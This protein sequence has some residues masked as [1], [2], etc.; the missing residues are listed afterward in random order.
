MQRFDEEA[1]LGEVEAEDGRL[2]L[3]HCTEIAGGTRQISAGEDV[4]FEVGEGHLGVWEARL[5]TRV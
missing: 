3:F 2:Y 4:V 1:G 5:V